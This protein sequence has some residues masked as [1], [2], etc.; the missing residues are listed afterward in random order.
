V[1]YT[2]FL[3]TSEYALC[4]RI[5]NS[6]NGEMSKLYIRKISQT[7]PLKYISLICYIYA[8]PVIDISIKN[9]EIPYSLYAQRKCV[10]GDLIEYCSIRCSIPI[11]MEIKRSAF[12]DAFPVADACQTT[13]LSISK[14][15]VE[16]PMHNARIC[17]HTHTI[18]MLTQCFSNCHNKE[19]H[20]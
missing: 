12:L 5:I 4:K 18:L 19:F 17:T 11:S 20:I 16:S 2:Y 7:N 8:S 3:K 1:A 9:D 13:A 10:D 6:S 14:A 15:R